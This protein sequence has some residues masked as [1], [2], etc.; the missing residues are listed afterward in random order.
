MHENVAMLLNGGVKAVLTFMGMRFFAKNE[1][2]QLP[3]GTASQF[4]RKGGSLCEHSEQIAGTVVHFW[5]PLCKERGAAQRLLADAASISWAEA[6]RPARYPCPCSPENMP[7][8]TACFFQ[9]LGVALVY[10]WVQ[11]RT[12]CTET[13]LHFAGQSL[14]CRHKAARQTGRSL[15]GKIRKASLMAALSFIPEAV[16]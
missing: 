10:T 1:M 12:N 2:P 13:H 6:G 5:Q 15:Q 3:R 4:G 16:E 14:T 9:P 7:R 11:I 8:T